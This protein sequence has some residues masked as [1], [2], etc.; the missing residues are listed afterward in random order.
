MPN[1][2]FYGFEISNNIIDMS[3]YFHEISGSFQNNDKKLFYGQIGENWLQNLHTQIYININERNT[4]INKS[5][6]IS[7]MGSVSTK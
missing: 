7:T 2:I 5:L 3:G 4:I 1:S 6:G